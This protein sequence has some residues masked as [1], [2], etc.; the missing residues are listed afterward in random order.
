MEINIILT[1]EDNKY[2]KLM[3]SD[4]MKYIRII[5]MALVTMGVIHATATSMT[6][7]KVKFVT[8]IIK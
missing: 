3:V 1:T 4:K 7:E 5:A 8:I 2:L 6:M